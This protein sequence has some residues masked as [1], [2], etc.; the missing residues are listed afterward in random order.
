[1][2]SGHFWELPIHKKL[3]CYVVEDTCSLYEKLEREFCQFILDDFNS[4]VLVIG[5]W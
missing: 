4:S 5:L 1:M 3:C 2:I